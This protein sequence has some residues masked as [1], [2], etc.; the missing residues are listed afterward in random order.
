CVSEEMQE[1]IKLILGL[2]SKAQ[3][4][5]F[6]DDQNLKCYTKCLMSEMST[7]SKHEKYF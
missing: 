6:T 5:E 4:G 7:V 2:I 3:K 1:K